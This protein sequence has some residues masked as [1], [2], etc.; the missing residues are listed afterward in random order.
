MSY[1]ASF[2]FLSIL[3]ATLLVIH[4]LQSID[5]NLCAHDMQRISISDSHVIEAFGGK[6][7]EIGRGSQ[8][9]KACSSSILFFR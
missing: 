1:L 3:T 9:V 7:E 4:R 2:A 8:Y 6:L 5:Q